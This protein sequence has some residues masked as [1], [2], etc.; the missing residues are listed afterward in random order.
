MRSNMPHLTLEYTNNL[1]KE[2]D[3]K[4][5]FSSIHAGLMEMGEFVLDEIKSRAAV[6][7]DFYV[8]DGDPEKS[9]IHLKIALLD[10]RRKESKRLVAERCLDIVSTYFSDRLQSGKCQVCVELVDI[11]SDGYFKADVTPYHLRNDS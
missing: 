8:G 9:F 11:R 7:D 2:V 5:L 1:R 10:V 3:S 4:K 6:V